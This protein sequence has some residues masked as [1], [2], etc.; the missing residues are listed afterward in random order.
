M[1]KEGMGARIRTQ[2]R[3]LN[4]TISP[5]NVLEVVVSHQ[6]RQ[7]ITTAAIILHNCFQ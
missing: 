7:S 1:A 2:V 3:K 5:T 6:H 4:I